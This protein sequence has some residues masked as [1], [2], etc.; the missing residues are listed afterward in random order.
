[1]QYHLINNSDRFLELPEY[2]PVPPVRTELLECIVDIFYNSFVRD[3]LNSP[4][5]SYKQTPFLMFHVLF[6]RER[7]LNI[8]SAFR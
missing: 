5:I 4:R 7:D 3:I 2:C 1:M 8:L 6:F